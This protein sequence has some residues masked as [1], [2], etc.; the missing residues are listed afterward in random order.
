[1]G[2][3]VDAALPEL[4]LD[5]RVPRVLHLVVR[6]ARQLRRDLRPPVFMQAQ[7]NFF[8]FAVVQLN[9]IA[10]AINIAI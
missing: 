3:G 10:V 6:S 5:V 9:Q 2:G 8:V 1:V 7:S 4:L